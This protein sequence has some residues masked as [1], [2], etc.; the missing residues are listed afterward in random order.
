[1]PLHVWAYALTGGPPI[2]LGVASY[3]G[4]RADVAAVHGDQFRDSGFGLTVQGLPPGNY[5]LAVFAWSS[6]SGGFVPGKV[7]RVT[8]R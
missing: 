6:V 5:D 2:L 4:V 1:M 7:A 8:V 3:G